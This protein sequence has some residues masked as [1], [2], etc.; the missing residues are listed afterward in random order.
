[1]KT[2]ANSLSTSSVI[3]KTKALSAILLAITLLLAAACPMQAQPSYISFNDSSY[4]N[5]FL[6][7]DSTYNSVVTSPVVAGGGALKV[8]TP[9]GSHYGTS[10]NYMFASK[11]GSEPT[12]A[13]ARYYVR[14]DSNW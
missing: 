5:N 9:Q 12:E 3:A 7:W 1:M 10:L 2:S 8:T 11:W 4:I 13:Y 14:F 6:V